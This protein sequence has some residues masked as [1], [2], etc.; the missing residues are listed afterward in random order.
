[1]LG[2][3]SNEKMF[4]IV[5]LHNCRC[6]SSLDEHYVPKLWMPFEKSKIYFN[7][8]SSQTKLKMKIEGMLVR[9]HVLAGAIAL[10]FSMVTARS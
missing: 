4:Y 6:S 3:Q 10:Y 1:M 8:T 7:K 9:L 5:S 2:L